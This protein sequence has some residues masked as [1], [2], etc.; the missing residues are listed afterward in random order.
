MEVG[1]QGA[2]RWAE[3]QGKRRSGRSFDGTGRI[4]LP[5]AQGVEN[6]I[7]KAFLDAYGD[8]LDE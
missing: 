4:L 1:V 8:A 2:M 6:R 7:D 3:F 5:R